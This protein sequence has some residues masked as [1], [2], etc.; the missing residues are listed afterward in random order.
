MV[1][2]AA[3]LINGDKKSIWKVFRKYA[4]ILIILNLLWFLLGL[5]F[6]YQEFFSLYLEKIGKFVLLVLL[7]I[8]I[9]PARNLNRKQLSFSLSGFVI[10]TFLI[11][12]ISYSY[13]AGHYSS[14]AENPFN[15]SIF[16]SGSGNYH[17]AY[18]SMFV[19]CSFFLCLEGLKI[20]RKRL[21]RSM[22]YLFLFIFFASVFVIKARTAILAFGLLVPIYFILGFRRGSTLKTSLLFTVAILIL[23]GTILWISDSTPVALIRERV[24]NGFSNSMSIR[25]DTWSCALEVFRSNSWIFGVGS[26]NELLALRECYYHNFLTRQFFDNFNAHND[27]L[28]ILVRNG[29]V[30][31]LLWFGFLG[32]LIIRNYE[33]RNYIGVIFVLLFCICG[34]TEGLLSRIWGILFIGTGIG[35]CLLSYFDDAKFIGGKLRVTNG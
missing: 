35:F 11:L 21:V 1:L 19:V 15:Y 31:L 14:G 13:A 3:W 18:I 10:S 2:S 23:A 12:L 28:L 25:M 20:Y 4:Y 27:F 5:L 17:P 33:V 29:I 26:G 6:S 30:G 9:I 8:L 22:I 16:I 32:S 24:I 34:L 7:P